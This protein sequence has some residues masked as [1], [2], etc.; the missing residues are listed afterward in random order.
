MHLGNGSI[1]PGCAVYGM[2]LA[3]LGLITGFIAARRQ[4]RPDAARLALGT[5]LIFA[6]QAFN[7]PAGVGFSGHLVGGVLLAYWFGS[8]LGALS[9]A[10]VLIVQS[11]LLGDGG[12][13]A[14]GTNIVNMAIIPCLIVYPLWKHWM[15]NRDGTARWISLAVA[16]WISVMLAATACTLEIIGPTSWAVAMTMLGTHAAIGVIEAA[17]T[18]ALARA[19]VRV[20]R[21]AMPIAAGLFLAAAW[22]GSSPWPDGLEYT[23]DHHSLSELGGGIIDRVA[24]AQGAISSSFDRFGAGAVLIG[25]VLAGAAALAMSRV[26]RAAK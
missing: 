8:G 22:L 25:A 2:G 7:I 23:F 20:P 12:W 17:A 26:A 16:A 19:D 5:A 15:G 4:Q 10:A 9:M 3:G 6:A 1:T 18:V 21:L 24:T 14:L 11:V 13:M